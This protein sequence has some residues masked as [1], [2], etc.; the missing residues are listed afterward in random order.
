MF[1]IIRQSLVPIRAEASHRSEMASQLLFGE[2]YRVLNNDTEK[3]WI[4]IICAFDNYEGW[5]SRLQH[6]E[7]SEAYFEQIESSDYKVSLDLSSPIL[8]KKERMNILLGSV[9]PFG[10]NELF[11]MEETLAFGG[12][13]KPLSQKW[14][15]PQMKELALKYLNTPYLWGGRSPF[16]IDCSGFTQEVFKICG[17]KLNRDASQQFLQ[18]VEIEFE[19]A[20]AG[21]L[22]F[23][24]ND[25]KIDH[26]GLILEEN[27]IIH[28]SGHVKIDTISEVGIQNAGGEFTHKLKG[29]RRLINK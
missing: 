7:I 29:V 6:T 19:N 26:V 13:S 17:Y 21:D 15:M 28:A 11:K 18:G 20:K 23:F 10:S 3:D 22:A 25:D 24:G 9:L 14:K 27:R 2:H 4:R 1:G 8:F 5:I 12:E 16:G